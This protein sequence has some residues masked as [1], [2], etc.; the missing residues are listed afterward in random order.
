MEYRRSQ[1][2]GV[3]KCPCGKEIKK[4]EYGFVPVVQHE[5]K[6]KFERTVCENCKNIKDQD[7]SF[8]PDPVARKGG[9]VS[10][11]R[12]FVDKDSYGESLEHDEAI[13]KPAQLKMVSKV[14]QETVIFC[15]NCD[16]EEPE[17]HICGDFFEENEAFYCNQEKP[18]AD[19]H[20]CKPCMIKALGIRKVLK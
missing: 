17:C 8:Q 12:N 2:L 9:L 18:V 11:N 10:M 1:S 19:R 20:T 6:I 7:G 13:G 3:I 16:D 5:N 14:T 15:P 4:G